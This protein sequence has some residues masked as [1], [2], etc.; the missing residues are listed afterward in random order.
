[1]TKYE[2]TMDEIERMALEMDVDRHLARRALIAA[3]KLHAD[4]ETP[5][6]VVDREHALN[7]ML[8]KWLASAEAQTVASPEEHCAG[9]LDAAI[10]SRAIAV[11][12]G[13]TSDG[14]H[15]FDELY[16]HRM[17]LTAALLNAW[18]RL[19]GEGVGEDMSPHK[20]WRHSDGS[21]PFGGGWFIVVA[22]LPTGQ[23]SYHYERQHWDLFQIPE[24]ELPAPFDGHDA[25]EVADRMQWYLED[26]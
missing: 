18:H 7:A 5:W 25:R 20:S 23:I 22:E 8:E 1:M 4:H 11:P 26:V 3:R 6:Y 16:R 21:A 19:E 24:R 14:Y 13:S 2:P 9:L 17:L 15:T 12:S 10:A